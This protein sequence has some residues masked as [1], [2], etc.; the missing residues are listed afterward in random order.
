MRIRPVHCIVVLVVWWSSHATVLGQV[1]S[2][3]YVQN[4]DSVT[5]PPIP[6]PPGW[7]STQNRIPGTNDFRDSASV[8]HS[9]PNAVLSVNGRLAQA[10]FSPAFDFVGVL[11]DSMR[12]WMRQTATHLAR[13]VVEAS[14]DS[15][16]AFGIRIG[17]TLTNISP[18]NYVLASFSLPPILNTS[19]SVKFR[20]SVI[21]DSSSGTTSTL[22]IDDVTISARYP[23]DLAL[24]KVRFEP[25][26]PIEGDSVRAFAVIR[27]IG[28]AVAQ[29]FACEFYLDANR[30]S[31]PQPSE[32]VASVSATAPLAIADSVE[33]SAW[34]GSYPAGDTLVIAKVVYAPD[35]R[36][37]N[38]TLA[39]PLRVGYRPF[40]VVINEIMYAPTG[41]EPEWVELYNTRADSISLKGWQVSDN[42]VASKHL[43]TS[44]PIRIPPRGYVLL[45]KDSLGLVTAHNSGVPARIINVPGFPTLNNTGDAVVLYDNRIATMDSLTYVPSWG[46]NTGGRSLERV[47]PLGASTSQLNWGTSRHPDRSSPGIR[48]SLTRKDRDLRLDTLITSPVAP[49]MGDSLILRARITNIG[50]ESAGPYTVAFFEDVN[51]DSIP[52]SGELLGSFFH[53]TPLLPLETME[54]QYV[55]GA[56]TTGPHLFIS[57]VL[58]PGDEDTLNNKRL[59]GVAV[60]Y[61]VGSMRIN[62]VMYAPVGEPEWVEFQN[63]TADSINIQNWRISNRTISNRYTLASAR[64]MIP[65]SGYLVIT[66]DTALFL[67][68]H[69][70]IPGVLLQVPSLPT[71]LFSNSGDAVVLYDNR[72]IQM[73]TMS[74][75]SQ[76]GGTGGRSLERVD[77]W[78]NPYDST[79]WRGSLAPIGS[80]PGRKNSVTHKDHD[81]HLA[82][83]LFSPLFP[84]VGDS[85]SV[86]ARIINRGTQSATPFVAHFFEDTNRDSI[87]QQNEIIAALSVATP[88]LSRDSI[89]LTVKV[90][91][92]RYGERQFI[93]KVAYLADEDTTN[94]TRVNTFTTG[95][96]AGSIRINEVM[97]APVGSVPEWVEVMNVS[98]DTV[99]MRNWKL[100]NRLPS[101]RYTIIGATLLIPPSGLM[102]VTKDTA[103]LRNNYP[104]SPNVL[105]QCAALPTFLWNNSGD[106]V[107]LL[108][109]RGAIVDSVFYHPTW[110]GSAGK[111]LERRDALEPTWDSTNWASSRDT[112]GATPGRANSVETFDHDL[113]ILRMPAVTAT[114]GTNAT[115][116]VVVQNIGRVTSGSFTL[117]LY[118]DTNRDSL[119]EPEELVQQSSVGQAI[120]RRDSLTLSVEWSNPPNGLSNTIAVIDYPVDQ[121]LT[122]NRMIST[123]RTGFPERSVVINEIMYAPLMG[124]AEYVEL[125]N[126]STGDVDLNGW[127]I[128][129]R[130]SSSGTSNQYRLATKETVLHPGE[131][132]VLCS[133]STLLAQFPH[134]QQREPRLIAIA[135]QS[136]LSLNNDGDDIVLRDLL[137][138]P[139]DSVSYLPSWHNAN[140][141]NKAGRS[142]ERINPQLAANDPRSWS[143]CANSNGG[144]PGSTN[145]IL[146]V[147]LPTQSKLSF[148]PNPFS[149]DGDGREDFTLVQ[150][151][152]PLRTALINIKIYDVKGRLIRLLANNEPSGS[153]GAIVWNGLDSE[154]QK[155]R[156]GMYVVLLEAIDEHGTHLETAKGVVVLAGQL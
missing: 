77:V 88:L 23:E 61:P 47:D 155:A 60:G 151:E 18:N 101:S 95:F 62:E 4:F 134:L 64:L 146:A 140:V 52:Q 98:P 35:Q 20:W 67:Q 31:L 104:G 143:T 9:A 74:Y 102:V 22:R 5:T 156:I 11:P 12:F 21:P 136:N 152:L 3:P 45:T 75:A 71:F 114:P 59:A 99:D 32:L 148:S 138:F 1:S 115:V 133:D 113:H 43:I 90:M 42:N 112:L 81:L 139:I 118:A 73:D 154:N 97:Y 29:G 15:G 56:S 121:R 135:N 30:D 126:G 89:D 141:S 78:Q 128:T 123:V 69:H 153:R 100:G 51:G 49:V 144:T 103:L 7:T 68:R 38:N 16:V 150:Y 124:K 96:A 117:Q 28:E 142:L 122:N 66:K 145:S 108:D 106:A 94:N 76:W 82:S 92:E 110:G 40:S 55:V 19:H 127:Q 130:P 80:S 46:G 27:N 57:T 120:T 10:L 111:S 84:I 72:N 119:P 34:V 48:N 39:A 109:N 105:V 85:V 53:P 132:F 83:L 8:P 116:N 25:D 6:L 17:D 70:L 149:P 2:F 91:A 26:R 13:V 65:P 86:I 147:S 14:L 107:V 41:D 131:F 37:E 50:H 79:N 93:G 36:L 137:G 33:L 24:N 125:F 58:L 63:I 44:L 54:E 129:D 87:P